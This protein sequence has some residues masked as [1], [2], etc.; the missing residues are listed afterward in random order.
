MGIPLPL[1]YNMVKN[2]Y[3]GIQR[4]GIGYKTKKRRGG[5]LNVEINAAG[6]LVVFWS[7][8]INEEDGIPL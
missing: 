2:V 5:A 4:G 1:D 8:D 7:K 6:H 3:K